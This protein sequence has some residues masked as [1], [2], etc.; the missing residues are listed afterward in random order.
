MD[1]SNRPPPGIFEMGMPRQFRDIGFRGVLAHRVA[2]IALLR[3]LFTDEELAGIDLQAL[4]RE[5]TRG[6][7]PYLWQVEHDVIWSAPV[8]APDGTGP[9]R[10][11]FPIEVQ[12]TVEATMSLRMLI[13]AA[14]LGFQ[15]DRDYERPL[16]AM[17]PIVL[18][19]EDPRWDACKDPAEMFG[20]W[21]PESVPRMR[22]YVLDLCRVEAEAGSGNVM[23]LLAAVLRGLR[24]EELF[25]GAKALYRRLVELGD[26]PLENSFFELVRALCDN[27]WPG[28]NWE[29][30]SNMAE[31]V[32][33]L[34]ERT[35]T[36]PEKWR[37][38]YIA[39]GH[40]EGRTEGLAEGRAEGR[41][42]LLV[43]MARQRFGEAVA[44][45]MSD[46]LKSVRTESALDGV[47][48]WL[49]TCETGEALI[50]RIRQM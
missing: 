16:P 9:R 44:S 42:G 29:D 17:V 6:T 15:L 48:S 46:L 7:G 34:E 18:Y 49:L 10:V 19:T 47:G 33:A 39:E 20:V 41:V 14:L 27:K 37:A 28:Q 35:I 23:A 1:D 21:F 32:N 22:H 25:A 2:M 31:L 24:E 26:K 36:W 13:Y 3:L 43:S 12:S 8:T 45:T 38:N 11:Y 5:P 40:A 4:Q 50:A 30:C